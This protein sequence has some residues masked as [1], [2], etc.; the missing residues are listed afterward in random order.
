MS[1]VDIRAW[2]LRAM[3]TEHLGVEV[4]PSAVRR[5]KQRTAC[6]NML[7]LKPLLCSECGIQRASYV[8]RPAALWSA[9]I[10]SCGNVLP[11]L[12]AR[13]NIPA[14]AFGLKKYRGGIEPSSSTCENEHT[15]A[16]VGQAE[17]LGIQNPPCCCS[18]GSI[19][20][21]RVRPP[22]P[23]RLKRFGFAHQGCEEAVER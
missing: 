21:T 12:S 5:Y 4:V 23:C 6:I 8:C 9:S 13:R 10:S 18:L 7:I 15:A 1:Q 19:H 2:I 16:S 20:P 11:R 22:S 14:H 3:H 17:I